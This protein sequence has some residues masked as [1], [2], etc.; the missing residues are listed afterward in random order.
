MKTKKTLFHFYSK[1]Q[2]ANSI[3]F[4]Q[5]KKP[6]FS[7]KKTGLLP[8]VQTTN[9][10]TSRQVAKDFFKLL[11]EAHQTADGVED[12]VEDAVEPVEDQDPLLAIPV[13]VR[14]NAAA[15]GAHPDSSGSHQVEV[16]PFHWD[17]RLIPQHSL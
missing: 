10:A 4:L 7:A 1:F 3:T 5:K 9:E 2:R 14:H 16:S 11:A 17:G 8:G 6:V 13:E 12:G 15:I